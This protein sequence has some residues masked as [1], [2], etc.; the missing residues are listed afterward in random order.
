VAPEASE[1]GSSRDPVA[2]KAEPEEQLVTH[3]MHLDST[4][5]FTQLCARTFAAIPGTKPNIY[6]D[7]IDVN[8]GVVRVFRNWLAEEAKDSTQTAEKPHAGI[9]WA[10]DG[11]QVGIRLKVKKRAWH[12]TAAVPLLRAASEDMPVSYEIQYEGKRL[13]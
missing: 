5:L 6:R 2:P 4:E 11:E 1:P 13:R 9:V 12:R 8:D 7:Y 10:N 3:L